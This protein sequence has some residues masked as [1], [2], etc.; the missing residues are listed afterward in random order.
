MHV[1]GH[2]FRYGLKIDHSFLY[3]HIYFMI[4]KIRYQKYFTFIALSAYSENP[5][6]RLRDETPKL[7]QK[8][9]RLPQ[10]HVSKRV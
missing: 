8:V 6:L 2:H 5:Y 4:F 7:C 1:L 3:E 9:L 10:Q